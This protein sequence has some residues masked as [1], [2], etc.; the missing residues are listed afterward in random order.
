M[1]SPCVFVLWETLGRMRGPELSARRDFFRATS[2]FFSFIASTLQVFIRPKRS[3]DLKWKQRN[4]PTGAD[5]RGGERVERE[6]T[7]MWMWQKQLGITLG[8]VQVDLC[9]VSRPFLGLCWIQN[10]NDYI[11]DYTLIISKC[12]H[13]GFQY[14][15]KCV[16]LLIFPYGPSKFLS[17]YSEWFPLMYEK[18]SW[19][20]YYYPSNQCWYTRYWL[21]CLN[22]QIRFHHLQKSDLKIEFES[23]IT[24]VCCVNKASEI[25]Q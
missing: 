3:L 25:Q 21:H 1:G 16:M 20:L 2:V 8:S 18:V 11:I 14:K 6:E 19:H 7:R 22:Q 23:Q 12:T 10:F 13:K 9:G 24:F 4:T 5:V 17:L 15:R